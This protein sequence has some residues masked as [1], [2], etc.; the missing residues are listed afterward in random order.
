MEAIEDQPPSDGIQEMRPWNPHKA[1]KD[2][3]VGDFYYKRKNYRA[4]LDRYK[5]ALYYKEND[6][7]ATFRV[8]Q[9]EEKLGSVGEAQTNYEAYLRIL[10]EGPFAVDAQKAL[11]RL[12]G[13]PKTGSEK[14][15]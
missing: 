4:A 7:V 13:L 8:A 14:K 1:M 11:E 6:A 9:C 5:E 2:I 3:E 10:P 15:Y 12:S